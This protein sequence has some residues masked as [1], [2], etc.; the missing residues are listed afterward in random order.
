MTDNNNTNFENDTNI[1]YTDLS[2]EYYKVTIN[3]NTFQ[4]LKLYSDIYKQYTILDSYGRDCVNIYI[5]LR[6]DIN[7]AYLSQVT[8]RSSCAIGESMMRGLSTINMVKALLLFVMHD[9][10]FDKIYLKDKSEVD[11]VLPDEE[12]T[13]YKISLGLLSFLINGKTWYQKH[14]GAVVVSDQR[15][16]QLD[17]FDAQ[18]KSE[19]SSIE[20]N[21]LKNAIKESLKSYGTYAWIHNV[22]KNATEIIVSQIGKPW[23]SVF[24]EL[25]SDKGSFAN[26]MKANMG[27]LLFE[28][29]NDFIEDMFNPPDLKNINMYIPRETILAYPEANIE[30]KKDISPIHVDK[31]RKNMLLK[32]S[33]LFNGVSVY[34]I[35]GKKTLKSKNIKT[36]PREYGRNLIGYM[37]RRNK[38]I[39]G[40]RRRMQR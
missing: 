20:A 15:Q 3:G 39:K 19:M 13:V 30:F 21:Q 18:L 35:G 12:T 17:I 37:N 26:K 31:Q 25:F 2:E 11:C 8:Y 1:D 29:T 24:F 14:F 40:T 16:R 38:T 4:I 6:N 5:Q 27:C 34:M 9:T 22:M 32:S 23:R 33:M 28:F 7:R 36:M 10:D